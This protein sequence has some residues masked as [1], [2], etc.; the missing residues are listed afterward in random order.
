ME[1]LTCKNC[2][3]AAFEREGEAYICQHC[4]S[5]TV[6]KVRMPRKRLMMIIALLVVVIAGIFVLYRTLYSVKKDIEALS[7]EARASNHSLKQDAEEIRASDG[8]TADDPYRAME[9]SL[10]KKVKNSL[11]Y[12]PLEKVMSA[13]RRMPNH[14]AF[15]IALNRDG[16]YAYGYARGQGTV[17]EAATTA[18]ESCEKERKER[19]MKTMCIPYLVDDH[20]AGNLAR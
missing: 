4:G 13:Y 11:H 6:P 20:V 15:F 2:G 1:T 14:K 18:F 17:K 12:S 16:A 3:G 19:Q 5:T 9:A 8:D 10:H 7:T